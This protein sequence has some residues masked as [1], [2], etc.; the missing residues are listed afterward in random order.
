MVEYVKMELPAELKKE[1]AD[2]LEQSKKG[3]IKAGI[4]EVTKAIERGNAL[5]VV[6]AEDV[7]PAEIVMH[8][9][10]L[11]KE[12]EIPCAYIATKKELGEKAGFNVPTSSV[13]VL[14]S[15]VDKEIQNLGKKIEELKK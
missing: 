7:T 12:K 15:P 11:C 6:I 3:K 13:A 2:L 10:L 8:L 14:K 9:P 5:L 4:N 1:A